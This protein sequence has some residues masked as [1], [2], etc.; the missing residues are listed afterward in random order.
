MRWLCLSI[1][2]TL[3]LCRTNASAQNPSLSAVDYVNPSTAVAVG[4]GGTAVRSNDGGVTWYSQP[5]GS[6][7]W[8]FS[9]KFTD[10]NTGIAVGG[11]NLGGTESIVHTANGGSNWS[12]QSSTA[13]QVL[14]GVSF[15]DANTAV[16]V[17][18][19]GTALRTTNAGSTWVVESSSQTDPIYEVQ[20]VDAS[21]GFAVGW[22]GMILHT[23]NGGVSWTRQTS[24]TLWNLYG[25]SFTSA[26]TGTAVGD[27]GHIYRTVDGGS[28]WT[29]QTS[30]VT[31]VLFAVDFTD[32]NTGTAVGSAGKILRTT[33]GGATWT[34]QTSGTPYDLSGVSFIDANNGIAVG[35]NETI[36]RTT[37][38]GSTWTIQTVGGGTP[39][40]PPPAAP[41]LVSPSSGST[42]QPTSLTLSWSASSGATSYRAQVSTNS[43][44]STTVSDQ[45][46][47]ASTSS[48]VSGLSNNTTYFWRVNATNSNGTSGWSSASSFTTVPLMPGVTT[49]S[50]SG[51]TANSTLANGTVNPNGSACTAW[52]EWGTS[53]SLVTYTTTGSQSIGSGTTATAVSSSVT[54]LA[55]STTYYYRT[56]GQNGAGTQKGGIMSFTTAASA[57]LPPPTVVTT[58]ASVITSSS[59]TINGTANPN[60]AATTAWFEW[61]T[62]NTLSTFT[63]TAAQSVGSG[64]TAVG[65]SSNLTGLTSGTIY[66]YRVAGQNS[67]GT[68]KDAILSFTTAASAPPQPPAAPA[69][70]SPANGATG[71][72]TSLTLSWNAST[73][74]TSYRLQVSTSSAFTT[75]VV[76]QSGLSG[77]SSLV[78][79]LLTGTTYYWRVNASNSGGASAWSATW[80][81]ATALPVLAAPTPSTPANGATNQ[82]VSPT[83]TW[84]PVTGATS[85]HVQVSTSSAFTTTAVDLS[86]I[87][88]TSSSVSGLA[89][90]SSY[91]WRVCASNTGST[92]PYSNTCG[93]V[94]GSPTFAVSPPSLNFG[95]VGLGK[96]SSQSVTVTNGGTGTL[97]ISSVTSSA[98]VYTV[99]PASASI[100]PGSSTNFSITF[101]PVMKNATVSATIT[102]SHNAAGSPGTVSVIGQSGNGHI[103]AQAAIS[104]SITDM[105]SSPDQYSVGQNYPNPF[106]PT[107]TIA[108][109]LPEASTVRLSIYNVIGQEV[110]RLVDG[111]VG[112]GLQS[113]LWN[114]SNNS[115]SLLPSGIY[116]YRIHATS[117]TSGKEFDATSRMT[118]MK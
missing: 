117:L 38:G 98:G 68:S 28:T 90:N 79:G 49:N 108:Y 9:V 86:G 109:F 81:Y 27:G 93:F 106:N 57:A 70:S 58:A 95:S 112:Q 114:A 2:L 73:G 115:G 110:A 77:T 105:T 55:A 26:T 118:L 96:S 83:L 54:G 80:S 47:L 67:N 87:T 82:S 39:P 59:G 60:G 53:S 61:G 64:T 111:E 35:S 69:L 100:A 101:A 56:A 42:N 85:Y 13:N 30:G 12:I 7:K 31:N 66:Y 78:S 20:M 21:T 41:A 52:F 22:S 45:S 75:T 33:N 37:N 71:L 36:L 91:Y 94:T 11:D 40:P 44:F 5:T 97:T 50:A 18:K 99:S 76:D 88:S 15:I 25:V 51:T 3:L 84:Q 89:N 29:A 6:S 4:S 43:A 19:M 65:V 24:G 62:S 8:L 102:F 113:V 104:N 32:A 23:G 116:F 46:G 48:V 16:A 1:V 34:A 72:A 92:S 10:A 74:A 63:A 14:L 107:T 103:S 17:G